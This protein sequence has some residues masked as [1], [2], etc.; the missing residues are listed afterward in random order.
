VVEETTQEEDPTRSTVLVNF[1]VEEYQKKEETVKQVNEPAKTPKTPMKKRRKKWRNKWER[2]R[3]LALEQLV[4]VRKEADTHI[5]KDKTKVE[6]TV[7][8]PP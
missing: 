3:K 7:R 6:T 4:L 2:F 5:K 1:T 8:Y